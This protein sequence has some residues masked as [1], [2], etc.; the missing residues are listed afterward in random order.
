LSQKRD[1]RSGVRQGE[2]QLFYPLKARRFDS[3]WNW[4][5]QDA[6]VT[7]YNVIFSRLT[8]ADRKITARCIAL[9]NCTDPNLPTYMQYNIKQCDASNGETHQLAKQFGQQLTENNCKVVGQLQITMI[10]LGMTMWL[11]DYW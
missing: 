1:S 10:V 2:G 3:S 4:V 6:L 8:T 5:R 9:F 7:Y 11:F